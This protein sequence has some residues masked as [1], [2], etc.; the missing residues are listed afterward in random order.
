MSDQN[1]LIG[2]PCSAKLNRKG[3]WKADAVEVIATLDQL[4]WAIDCERDAVKVSKR[5][6]LKPL[7]GEPVIDLLLHPPERLP[8]NAQAV[9]P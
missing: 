4:S 9:W 6:G 3:G 8:H 1:R 7:R 2:R 5:N